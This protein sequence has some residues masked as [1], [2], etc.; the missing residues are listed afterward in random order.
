MFT[1]AHLFPPSE[2]VLTSIVSVKIGCGRYFYWSIWP[3]VRYLRAIFGLRHVRTPP[4]VVTVMVFCDCCSEII[5]QEASVWK[6]MGALALVVRCPF[7]FVS[8]LLIIIFKLN[9]Q[10]KV[11]IRSDICGYLGQGHK[12]VESKRFWLSPQGGLVEDMT[13]VAYHGCFLLFIH[14]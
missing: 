11:V 12:R 4:C 3:F 9:T 6:S 5:H 7:K 8:T 1:W 13:V 2:A 10:K 14:C